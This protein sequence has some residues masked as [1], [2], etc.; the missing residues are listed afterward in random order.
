[1]PQYRC[2][3]IDRTTGSE[4]IRVTAAESIQQAR[5]EFESQGLFV[6]AIAEILPKPIGRR[7]WAMFRLGLCS[8]AAGLS[9]GTLFATRVVSE[10]VQSLI[11]GVVCAIATAF[12]LVL[13]RMA[14][15]ILDAARYLERVIEAQSTKESEAGTVPR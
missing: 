4:S 14:C 11:V 15:T 10:T 6:G 2:Q 5:R 12:V 9:M 7:S 3:T 13:A 1:M 8:L